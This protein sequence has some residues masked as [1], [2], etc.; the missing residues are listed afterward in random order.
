V[1][2]YRRW[3][4]E[5]GWRMGRIRLLAQAHLPPEIKKNGT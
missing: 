5:S 1:E 2:L 3:S 4:R